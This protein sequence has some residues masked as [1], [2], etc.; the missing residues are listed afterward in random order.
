MG[1]Y[2]LLKD[3]E[4]NFNFGGINIPVK[5]KQRVRSRRSY[6]YAKD[7]YIV[8]VLFRKSDFPS[9]I[10]RRLPY[11]LDELYKIQQ[12]FW[13]KELRKYKENFKPMSMDDLKRISKETVLLHKKTYGYKIEPN[14]ILQ[15]SK[16][17]LG[18]YA[19]NNVFIEIDLAMERL[20][21]DMFRYLMIHELTHRFFRDHSQG[22]WDEVSRFYPNY[23]YYEAMIQYI[24]DFWKKI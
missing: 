15:R 21:E 23:G 20:N 5:F 3:E 13:S 1:Q 2:S 11:V 22:F 18:W 16:E 10:Y 14:V 9:I 6:L 12:D 8:V 24:N 4:I 19:N 17:Y 7:E